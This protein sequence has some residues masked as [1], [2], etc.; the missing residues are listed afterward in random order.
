MMNRLSGLKDQVKVYRF[1]WD[2]RTPSITKASLDLWICAVEVNLSSLF[3]DKMLMVL[4][5]TYI[6]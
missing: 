4:F 2:M 6:L 5:E 3:A 1:T